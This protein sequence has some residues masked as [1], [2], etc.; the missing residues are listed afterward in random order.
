VT[1]K[2]SSSK[3]SKLSTVKSRIRIE[4]EGRDE[5]NKRHFKFSVDGSDHQ[6]PP[7]AAEQLVK[8]AT[9]LFAAF[10]NAGWNGFT[11]KARNEVLE[12]LQRRK[13]RSPTF[14]VATRLGWNSGAYVLPDQNIGKP[15]MPLQTA[16]SGLDRAMLDKYRVRG[17]LNDWQNQIA[18]PCEGNSRL[19]FS[20]CLAFTGPILRF[21]KGPKAGGFQ[22]WGDAETGK[23]RRL[24][25]RALY[26]AAIVARGA[27]KKGSPSPGIRLLVRLR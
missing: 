14:K 2:K 20:V 11:N 19:M 7:I 12:R 23:R 1:E 8:E 18:A 25:L 16:F 10:A 3:K 6:I 24:W 27:G 5:W 17:S 4:G 21:V 9:P 13:P 15:E 22:I 26:G